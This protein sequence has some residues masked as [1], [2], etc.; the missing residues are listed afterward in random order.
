MANRMG[1]TLLSRSDNVGVARVALAAFAA[2]LAFTLS[3]LEEIKVAVSE[4]VTN[5]VSHAYPG[6]EGEVAVSATADGDLLTVEVRDAGVGIPDVAAARAPSFTTVPD[7][8]GLG[9]VFME[10]FMDE[11]E[12][13]SAPGQG[14]TVTMR[15][16]CRP[17]A[18]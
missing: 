14:T 7:R 9:F 10:S 5:A 4:A 8:M 6:A 17:Q 15:K 11:L 3:D 16:R 2:Q 1:L 18:G 13:S 12:V